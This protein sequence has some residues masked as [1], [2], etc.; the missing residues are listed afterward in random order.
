MATLSPVKKYSKNELYGL[1]LTFS[2]VTT[3]T[4]GTG[5]CRDST[6]VIDINVGSTLTVAITS[7]GAN[8]LD[9]GAESSNQWYHYYVIMKADGTVAGLMSTSSSSPTLP[10]GYVYFRLVGS[11]RND[12]SS[13]L[14]NMNQV[15][16]NNIRWNYYAEEI[17]TTLKVLNGGT[18]TSFTDV[19]LSPLMP[20][21]STKA[22][23]HLKN[24]G[25]GATML[26]TNGS[27]VTS[28]HIDCNATSQVSQIMTTDASQ[29]VEYSV[30]LSGVCTIHV[31]GWIDL[32]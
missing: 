17:N 27:S 1:T 19:D 25:P 26:R 5:Y 9:T 11:R 6:N 32:I 12:G 23:I 10:S 18:A 24:T 14:L 16:G 15:D 28:G 2:S 7:S 4:I 3:Y 20:P 21:T 29:I 30:A 31:Y 8:G 13:N 22:M